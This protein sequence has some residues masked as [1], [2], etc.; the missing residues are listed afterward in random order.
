MSVVLIVED[1]EKNMKLARDVLQAK[2]Y[3]TQDALLHGWGITI[4]PPRVDLPCAMIK[5]E[6][7]PVTFEAGMLLVIQPHVVSADGRRGV[8]VGNLVAVEAGG[9]RSLQRYPVEF[10]QIPRC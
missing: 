9:V 1:N 4:E 3:R 5:R 2:G 8:Q 6:L 10:I 7:I